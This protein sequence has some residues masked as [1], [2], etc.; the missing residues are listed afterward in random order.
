MCIYI[1]M[2][3]NIYIYVY[4]YISRCKCIYIKGEALSNNSND[5]QLLTF[6][7]KDSMLDAAG[8]LNLPMPKAKA[9]KVEQNTCI[10]QMRA[11]L[12]VKLDLRI[13]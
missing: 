1:Y 8:V 5:F 4:I 2:Y 9:I 12:A 7:T 3:M 10:M 11:L 13:H 6:F